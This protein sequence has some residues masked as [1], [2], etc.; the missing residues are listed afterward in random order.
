MSCLEKCKSILIVK[1]SALGDV[2]SATSLV[3]AI[4]DRYPSIRLTWLVCSPLDR[5]ISG[6]SFIDD[7]IVWDRNG[8]SWSFFKIISIIRKGDFDVLLD[9][10]GVDRSALLTLFSGIINRIGPHNSW[11]VLYSVTPGSIWNGQASSNKRLNWL[12]S[13]L[14]IEGNR[15]LTPSLDISP[16]VVQKL[17]KRLWDVPEKKIFAPLGS[18]K[19]V[20]EWPLI[21]WEEFINFAL[22]DDWGVILIGS[23]KREK[24]KAAEIVGRFSSDRVVDFVDELDL[25]ELP[26]MASLCSIA[27]GADTGPLHLAVAAGVPTIGLFGPTD[28]DIVFPYYHKVEKISVSCS[29]RGCQNWKCDNQECLMDIPA[30]MV[31][32]RMKKLLESLSFS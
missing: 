3:R 1:Y 27:I 18:S 11:K 10:Q 19:K 28:P 22:D 32:W 23:G 7:V 30:D 31:F 14:G 16:Y 24:E 26:A 6:Q 15:S 9:L 8:G 29:H 13:C 12:G 5:I 21:R 4:R 17:D 2:I 20:K 25:E